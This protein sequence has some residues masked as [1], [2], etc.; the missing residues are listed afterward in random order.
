MQVERGEEVD[1]WGQG[2]DAGVV[3]D[4][5][6]GGGDRRNE[7]WLERRLVSTKDDKGLLDAET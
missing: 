5:G 7:V 3:G 2:L 1:V 6:F 4:S